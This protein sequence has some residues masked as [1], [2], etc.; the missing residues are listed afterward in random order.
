MSQLFA[1]PETVADIPEKHHRLNAL[2]HSL[3]RLERGGAAPR[4]ACPTGVAEI[5]RTL[6][7]R[8]V[9]GDPGE[10]G[11]GD[12]GPGDGGLPTGCLHE[13]LGDSAT[14]FGLAL[15]ARLTR[16]PGAGPVLWCGRRIDLYGPGLAACG[17]DPG[18]L[19]L[20][21]AAR[22]ADLLW[23]MEEGLRCPGLAAVV[24][25][26]ARL[27]LTTGRRLQLAAEAGGVTGLVLRQGTEETGASAATTRWRVTAAPGSAGPSFS[28]EP[29]F[30][31]PARWR[32]ELLRCRG[33]HSHDWLVEWN[34]ETGDLALA[35]AAG[36]RPAAAA[37]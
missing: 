14:G 27:D 23:A 33:G 10:G 24:G 8:S 25:E 17:L 29:C 3:R 16:L 9:D 20:A 32:I 19:I 1:M 37:G 28:L 11:P 4:P 35:A 5:D 36:D 21:E 26:V 13:I 31:G 2:R 12:G 34:D 22:P 15:L 7:G 18:R 6:G 30:L